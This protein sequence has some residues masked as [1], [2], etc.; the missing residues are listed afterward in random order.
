M[1]WMILMLLKA[2][3]LGLEAEKPVVILNKVDAEDIDVRPLDRVELNFGGKKGTAIVNVASRFIKPGEIGMLSEIADHMRAKSGV[4]ID[5]LPSAPP[6]SLIHIREKLAGKTL[7]DDDISKIIEDTVH[8]RLSDIE[9]TA[10]VTALYNHGMT[11]REVAALSKAMALTGKTLDLGKKKVYDKHSIGGV[12]G[13]ET[14]MVLVPIV[15]AAGLTIPKTSSRAITSPA[16]TADR[17]ECLA[18]VELGLD[19]IKRVVKKTNGCL[20]WG[21]S[22]DLAP[23]DDLFIK[24][25]YPLSIDPLLLPSVMSKKK[26]VGAKYLV[27][28]IPTGEGAKVKTTKEAENLAEKF[29]ELGKMLRINTVGASTYGEQPIGFAIGPALEAREALSTL[30]HGKGPNDLVDKV[31]NLAGILLDFNLGSGGRKV[32][33]RLLRDGKAYKK[34]KEIIA[35]QGGDPKIKPGDLPVGPKHAEV[36]SN[37]SGCVGW[38]NN[39]AVVEIARAAGTPNDKGAGILLRKKMGDKVK[40]GDTLFEIYAEKPYKLKRALRLAGEL[41][42][43]GVGKR[44]QMLIEKIPTRIEHPKYFILER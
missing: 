38:I 15:A 33:L 13:D 3:I 41:K 2:K 36:K 25:E 31:S 32:A 42:I 27:I 22:V 20:V 14:S 11:T 26:A 40:R 35:A 34:L 12:P 1:A 28:D 18:P 7:K 29:I 23:A 16:G 9:M 39:T 21:G 6:D 17:F 10:F 44:F 24:I 4:N 8:R 19:E 30:M 43:I 37:V 5:V